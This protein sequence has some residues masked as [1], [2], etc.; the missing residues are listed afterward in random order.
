MQCRD[1]C[2]IPKTSED[3]AFR[4]PVVNGDYVK[5]NTEATT[6]TAV[7]LSGHNSTQ[8]QVFRD[9]RGVDRYRNFRIFQPN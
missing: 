3:D 2:K 1:W 5:T 6:V 9:T 7:A 8:H 4:L